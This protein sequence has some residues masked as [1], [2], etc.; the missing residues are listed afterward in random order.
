MS[1]FCLRRQHRLR[2]GR[3]SETRSDPTICLSNIRSSSSSSSE[4]D[5]DDVGIYNIMETDEETGEVGAGALSFSSPDGAFGLSGTADRTI[6]L[7]VGLLRGVLFWRC[8]CS[9]TKSTAPAVVVARDR[10]GQEAARADG[11]G[12][13]DDEISL[14]VFIFVPI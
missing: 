14:K 5:A 11:L 2:Y 12:I 9:T 10:F 8:C 4:D 3:L 7:L 6:C 13:T 1:P